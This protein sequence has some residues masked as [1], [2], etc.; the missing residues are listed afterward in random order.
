M[1][2]FPHPSAAANYEPD[3]RSVLVVDDDEISRS[4]VLGLLAHRKLRAT[5]AR[6][7]R[8]AIDMV[9]RDDYG[10]IFMDC[11][12]PEAN[13]F[14]A[15]R[16]IRAAE[17]EGHVPIIAMTVLTMPGDRERCLGAGMDHY[18]SKPLL[19]TQLDAALALWLPRAASAVE[20]PLDHSA[21]LQL[22]DCLT[23]ERCAHLIAVFEEQQEKC[24]VEIAAAV[25]RDDR[26]RIRRIAHL[27]KGSSA[28]LGAVKLSA[29]CQELEHLSRHEDGHL[30]EERLDR[31]CLIAAEASLALRQRLLST[32]RCGATGTPRR[33]K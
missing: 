1:A 16:E 29:C 33:H 18:L 22:R 28:S 30:T 4:V 7:G 14:Q 2:A 15:T 9:A 5:V 21:V 11:V 13:G 23:P 27:L 17:V 26:D 8:E 31:L 32:T 10:A 25:Q 6:N 24:I 3:D 19:G 20:D 12:M